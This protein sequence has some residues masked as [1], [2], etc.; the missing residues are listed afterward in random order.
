ME[1]FTRYAVQ[2][3]VNRYD[4]WSDSAEPSAN[5]FSVPVSTYETQAEA[6][7]RYEALTAECPTGQYRVVRRTVTEQVL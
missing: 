2:F 3:Y 7:A 5:M 1:T 6:T 4:Y